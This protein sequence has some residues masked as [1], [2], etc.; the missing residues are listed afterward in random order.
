MNIGFREKKKIVYLSL[1]H[2][3][4]FKH[5]YEKEVCA[6]LNPLDTIRR[7]GGEGGKGRSQW[8]APSLP[9]GTRTH[10][11][12]E[13]LDCI[14]YIPSGQLL[15]SFN[16]EIYV[17]QHDEVSLAS[18]GANVR[19]VKLRG[20][21]YIYIY[22]SRVRVLVTVCPRRQLSS[23]ERGGVKRFENGGRSSFLCLSVFG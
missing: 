3:I 18:L 8:D 19:H 5:N 10:G 22:I 9:P 20:M 7:E 12:P 21:T 15:G 13:E 6:R 11:A 2:S 16:E 23:R 4:P 17:T 1:H 14:E